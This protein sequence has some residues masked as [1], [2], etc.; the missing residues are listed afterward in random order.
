[1]AS[2]GLVVMASKGGIRAFA[3]PGKPRFLVAFAPRNDKVSAGLDKVIDFDFS[4]RPRIVEF[5]LDKAGVIGSVLCFQR[6]LQS[7]QRTRI[8]GIAIEVGAEN[9]LRACGV[10]IDQKRAA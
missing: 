1:M 4:T 8:S 5:G 9:F 6:L 7:K 3:G 10:A 2:T